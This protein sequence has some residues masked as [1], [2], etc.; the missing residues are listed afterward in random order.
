MTD[1]T[2]RRGRHALAAIAAMAAIA[3]SVVVFTLPGRSSGPAFPPLHPAAAPAGWPH[4]TLPNRTAVL[5]YPRALHRL[6]GT[7]TP[8]RPPGSPRT[9]DSSSTSTPLPGKAASGCG[10]G[11]PSG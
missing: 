10:A 4:L 3:I 7:P 1:R 11:P 9:A 2:A 6:A 8:C 5:S